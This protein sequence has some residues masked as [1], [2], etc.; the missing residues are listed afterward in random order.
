M[1]ANSQSSCSVVQALRQLHHLLL[2]LIASKICTGAHSVLV[3]TRTAATE[4]LAL[5]LPST[6]TVSQQGGCTCRTHMALGSTCT[7][8]TTNA[9]CHSKALPLAV[10][11][12]MT[13]V[14][15]GSVLH[16]QFQCM[17][18]ANH[19]RLSFSPLT[20]CKVKAACV[21][22][23]YIRQSLACEDKSHI[24]QHHSILCH[25]SHVRM[26]PQVACQSA[27]V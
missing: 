26:Q 25:T 27:A 7:G 22:P 13:A 24:Q 11:Y 10:T 14:T 19:T 23:P 5:L 1:D 20:S 17:M 12:T 15:P 16:C 3:H 21:T 4:W 9:V 8:T 18:Q 6:V 2:R